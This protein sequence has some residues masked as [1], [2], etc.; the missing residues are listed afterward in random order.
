MLP[1]FVSLRSSA[2]PCY[3]AGDS[4]SPFRGGTWYVRCG[5]HSQG[6]PV[7]LVAGPMK[8]PGLCFSLYQCGPQEEIHFL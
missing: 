7:V 8:L 1:S 5:H 4:D 6:S 2:H 3:L